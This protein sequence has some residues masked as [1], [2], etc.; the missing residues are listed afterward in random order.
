MA[1]IGDKRILVVIVRKTRVIHV[2]AAILAFL[3][4]S[5]ATSA[6]QD[7]RERRKCPRDEIPFYK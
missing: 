4:T 3:V 1:P 5:I 6:Q 7:R 2:L